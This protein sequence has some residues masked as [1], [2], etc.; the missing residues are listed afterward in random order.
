MAPDT[1][2]ALVLRPGCPVRTGPR[3]SALA[4]LLT[5]GNYLPIGRAASLEENGC[6]IIDPCLHTAHSVVGRVGSLNLGR[7][8]ATAGGS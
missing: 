5:C 6:T 3:I 1:G 4:A 2:L 8:Q 7:T